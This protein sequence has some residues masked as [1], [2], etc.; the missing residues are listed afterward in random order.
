MHRTGVPPALSAHDHPVEARAE[1][2]RRSAHRRPAQRVAAE[3]EVVPPNP[4]QVD[5]PEQ[6]LGRE[7]AHCRRCGEERRD[8]RVGRSLVPDARADPDVR[9]RKGSDPPAEGR[10]VRQAGAG[11]PRSF[12]D[13]AR[14]VRRLQ[15]AQM[16]EKDQ[17]A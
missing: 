11:F 8:P 5:R 10:H 6:R 4:R 2:S 3:A 14:T 1:G 12:P 15:S 16:P 9:Q 13:F 7:K 17:K